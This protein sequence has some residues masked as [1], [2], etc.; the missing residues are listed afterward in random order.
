MA[1]NNTEKKNAFTN[2]QALAAVNA[3]LKAID[4]EL[5]ADVTAEKPANDLIEKIEHMANVA[6]KKRP[7]VESAT[8][9][10]NKELAAQVVK[11]LENETEKDGLTWEEIAERVKGI[12]TSAKAVAVIKHAPMVESFKIKGK[13]YYRIAATEEVAA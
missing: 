8:A 11:V 4:P 7:T 1:T 12:T 2:A 3:I 6:N 13:T 10:K 5:I 9:K